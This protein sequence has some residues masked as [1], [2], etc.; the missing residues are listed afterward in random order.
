VNSLYIAVI[1]RELFAENI[2]RGRG[3]Y[4]FKFSFPPLGELSKHCGDCS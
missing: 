4:S 2:M 3:W 1:V